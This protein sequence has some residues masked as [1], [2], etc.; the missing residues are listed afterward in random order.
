MTNTAKIDVI[1]KTGHGS[2]GKHGKKENSADYVIRRMMRNKAA[3]VGAVLILIMVFGALTATWITGYS[4]D[5]IDVLNAYASPS[6]KHWFGTD[7][8]GRDI[9]TR[10]MYGGRYT[11]SI[12]VLSV[13]ISAG[14]GVV[15][16]SIAGY[17]G[18]RLDNYIMRFL[19]II[20]AFPQILLAIA[21]SAA[22]G[23]GFDKCILALGLSGI[24]NFARLMR[25]NILTIRDTEYVEAATSINC[26]SARIIVRHVLPNA[27][28]PLIVQTSMAI[29]NAG[30]AAATLSFIG[31][32]VQPPT[33]EWGAMLS[34][35]R[36][37]IRYYPHLVLFPGIAIM[38]TTLSFNLIGDALRDALDPKM[39][40]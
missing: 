23:T 38:L 19:D 37:Y 30:L 14:F 21:L 2:A 7:E 12:G 15:I 11:L 33:P 6:W 3:L 29:A 10:L 40:N 18:G 17:Y 34:A 8:L 25:A 32:G 27:I 4:Y 16:G 36:D 24:P 5:A 26:S 9:L 22:F 31:L 39:K 13:A 20:Q 1:K 28:S 35:G